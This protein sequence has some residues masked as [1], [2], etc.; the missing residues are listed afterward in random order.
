MDKGKA[1]DVSTQTSFPA[2]LARKLA[3]HGLD[4]CSA[5]Y[6]TTGWWPGPEWAVELPPAGAGHQRG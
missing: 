1:L 5:L 6:V 4:G 2:E 3:A